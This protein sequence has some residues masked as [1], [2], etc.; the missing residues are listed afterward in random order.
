MTRAPSSG[1]SCFFSTAVR[2]SFTSLS[3]T[4][5]F[6][7]I[8]APNS[9]GFIAANW[10]TSECVT[11]P[12]IENN[13]L[14][15]RRRYE[16]IFAAPGRRCAGRCRKLRTSDSGTFC[17]VC[18]LLLPTPLACSAQDLLH[19]G[20]L[21]VGVVLDV[22]PLLRGELALGARVELAVGLVRTQVVAKAQ[23]AR[24]LVAVRREHVQVHGRFV[25]A[26]EPVPG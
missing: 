11:A 20:G 7:S 16:L 3:A 15:G 12:V 22:L 19:N 21:R 2:T 25:D 23:H 9:V 26:P 17:A 5:H 14:L 6:G 24:Q 13:P 18:G 4:C 8:V 10:W 1:V